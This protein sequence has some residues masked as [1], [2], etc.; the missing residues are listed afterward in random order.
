MSSFPIL[1]VMLI[2]L[3]GDAVAEAGSERRLGIHLHPRQ[4]EPIA[5]GTLTLIPR[6]SGY[7]YALQL[8]SPR[9]T[10][11]FLSMR[12]FRCLAGPGEMLCHLPYPYSLTRHITDD[13]LTDL[14]YDLLF[15]RKSAS[16]YGINAYNGVYYR[17]RWDGDGLRG[18]L[19]EVDL[20]PLAVPPEAGETRP[21]RAG[22]LYEADPG[23]HWLPEIRM[24]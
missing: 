12:P 23:A 7:D 2:L 19:H 22:D 18:E 10:D 5:L 3:A 4:G 11:Q 16:E 13:D 20:N 17:L 9:F 15:L 24:R 1:A 6:E 14:E 21:I 8:D